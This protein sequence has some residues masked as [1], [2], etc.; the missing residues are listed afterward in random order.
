VSSAL[1]TAQYSIKGIYVQLAGVAGG[2][3][4]PFA[5]VPPFDVDINVFLSDVLLP[6]IARM[7]APG[8]TVRHKGIAL[9]DFVFEMFSI[10][11]RSRC[12]CRWRYRYGGRRSSWSCAVYECT[13]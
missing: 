13:R 12:I 4:V 7:V 11:R 9:V 3:I 1:R 5:F 2:R 6:E 8:I 10:L